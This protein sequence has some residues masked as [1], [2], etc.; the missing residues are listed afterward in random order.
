MLEPLPLSL[1]VHLP[2]CVRKCPYCDFNSHAVR[3]DLPAEDYVAALLRDLEADLPLVWGRPLQSVFFG[4]GTPSLFSGAQIEKL[5]SGIRAILPLKPE[6]E[7]T[8]EANPGAVEYDRFAAYRDAGVNRVSLGAQSFSDPALSAIGRI[9]GSADIMRA[10]D[11]LHAA[12]IDNFNIDLMFALP[13]QTLQGSL[14]DVRAALACQ[15]AHISLYQLTIEPNTAFHADPPVL[16]SDDEAWEMQEACGALLAQEGF[17]QYEV[18]AWA[19][20]GRECLHNLNYW[21]YGDYL[22]IGAGAHGKIT[23]PSDQTVRRRVRIRHPAAWMKAVSEGGGLADDRTVPAADR[24]FEFFLNQ[25]RL[26]A[27]VLRS[28]F[29]ARTGLPWVQAEPAVQ[30]LLSRGLAVEEQGRL[31]PTEL[32]WRFSN[33]SQ[34][35]FLP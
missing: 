1:Y 7:V 31:V 33:E 19:R 9:H 2:W 27:G 30:E 34:A 14:D 29:E 21:Q 24:L 3:G 13:G 6:L 18:S 5:L 35:I 4:G 15:P 20:P 26:R 16:P 12:G 22:G 17:S 8:I 11:S 25:L 23:T 28:Q 32:G 10:V